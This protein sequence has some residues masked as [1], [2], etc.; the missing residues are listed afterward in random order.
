MAEQTL[1]RFFGQDNQLLYIGISINAYNRYKGHLQTKTWMDEVVSITL[2]PHINRRE[3][4]QAEIEAIRSE[5]PKYNRIRYKK[6]E[7]EPIESLIEN[8]A[9]SMAKLTADE[10]ATAFKGAFEGYAQLKRLGKDNG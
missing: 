2:E 10:I 4:E 9:E 8:M 3:V 1:Y 7:R 6:P 5:N